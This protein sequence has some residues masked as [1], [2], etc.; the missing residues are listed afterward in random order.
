MSRPC[1]CVS[2]SHSSDEKEQA[3]HHEAKLFLEAKS[4]CLLFNLLVVESLHDTRFSQELF[5][6]SNKIHL[7]S[8]CLFL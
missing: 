7:Q 5:A 3:V 2:K 6:I 1:N 8:D 4:T